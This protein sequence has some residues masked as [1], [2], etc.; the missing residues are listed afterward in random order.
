MSKHRTFEC[1]FK[2]V[3][4]NKATIKDVNKPG[5]V[6]EHVSRKVAKVNFT[7]TN[8]ED[9][10]DE[11]SRYQGSFGTKAKEDGSL[12]SHNIGHGFQQCDQLNRCQLLLTWDR[13]PRK[14]HGCIWYTVTWT[15]EALN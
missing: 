6:L 4:A 14:F 9:E 11:E 7:S 2:T 5:K 8:P 15:T 1:K 10:S 3:S 12:C 13:Q